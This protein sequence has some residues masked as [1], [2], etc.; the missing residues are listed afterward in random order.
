MATAE[1]C[2]SAPLSV[3]DNVVLSFLVD[4][5]KKR[6]TLQTLYERPDNLS[7]YTDII[8]ENVL[9]YHFANDTMGSILFD[10]TEVFLETIL[11][12]YA[13]LFTSGKNYGWPAFVGYKDEANLWIKLTEREMKAFS[14]SASVGICGFV[15]AQS[16]VFSAR[17]K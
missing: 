4:C 2:P 10:V 15:L 6:I 8:F 5:T 14:I 9:C 7:E 12:D 1:D 3:H 13:P 16:M 11:E 17:E